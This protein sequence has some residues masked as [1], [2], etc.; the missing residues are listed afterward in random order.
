MSSSALF[1][2]L[3]C[4]YARVRSEAPLRY[5]CHHPRILLEGALAAFGRL[6]NVPKRLLRCR[7]AD[8]AAKR[9]RRDAAVKFRKSPSSTEAA[10]AA[11]DTSSAKAPADDVAATA[12]TGCGGSGGGDTVTH[13]A[14]S[15]SPARAGRHGRRFCENATSGTRCE[16]NGVS[17]ATNRAATNTR[18]IRFL[19]GPCR[20]RRRLSATG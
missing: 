2:L 17:R 13:N 11:V 5:P 19:V 9:Y 16:R 6:A 14:A 3:L 20:S 15:A 18:A 12:A 10:P 1:L 7:T 4:Q 8:G